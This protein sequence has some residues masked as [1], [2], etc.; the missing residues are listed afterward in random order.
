MQRVDLDRVQLVVPVV[1]R[2]A[3]WFRGYLAQSFRVRL[4]GLVQ[5]FLVH[6]VYLVQLFPVHPE[7]M[8]HPKWTICL[9]AP[10]TGC[11]SPYI[12]GELYLFD[13]GIPRLCW[14]RVGVK[15]NTIPWGAD[16]LVALEY[17]T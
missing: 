13:I 16:F 11:K 9:G 7:H 4:V 14:K 15:G 10:K 17:E 12:T 8:I 3:S 1:A 5:S 2:L 6:P